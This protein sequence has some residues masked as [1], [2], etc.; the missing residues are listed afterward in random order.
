ML[1]INSGNDMKIRCI[2]NRETY[3]LSLDRNL[4]GFSFRSNAGLIRQ[5]G[6]ARFKDDIIDYSNEVTI[7]GSGDCIKVRREADAKVLYVAQL[8]DAYV[9][10]H[11][12]VYGLR[13]VELGLFQLVTYD[14]MVERTSSSVIA[15]DSSHAYINS[16][17]DESV[18][19]S[20]PFEMGV[21]SAKHYKSLFRCLDLNLSPHPSIVG[22]IRKVGQKYYLSI[23]CE[24]QLAAVSVDKT[25]G[26][27]VSS[28]SEVPINEY[29]MG[30]FDIEDKLVVK[31]FDPATNSTI[32]RDGDGF[33]QTRTGC[34]LSFEKS[35][36][37]V[38][39]MF[40]K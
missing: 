39:L 9:F 31:S 2:G 24:G 3:L 4:I 37:R 36:M 38:D 33:E 22:P 1:W 25:G 5:L 19:L 16:V 35:E 11:E 7:M 8:L 10:N 20:T 26:Y 14:G 30:V 34:F 32:Y 13:G 29:P 12:C 40:G 17:E 21:F 23:E 6:R 27:S 28:F 18:L 15:L